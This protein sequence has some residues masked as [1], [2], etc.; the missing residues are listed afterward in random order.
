MKISEIQT[1]HSL[2]F[3]GNNTAKVEGVVFKGTPK[4]ADLF[5]KDKKNLSIPYEIR[6]K[7]EKQIRKFQRK[8]TYDKFNALQKEKDIKYKGTLG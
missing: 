3:A 1:Y 2:Q 6:S 8:Q 4:N 7:I 5:V